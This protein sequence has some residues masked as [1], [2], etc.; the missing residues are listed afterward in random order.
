MKNIFNYFRVLAVGDI[1]GMYDKLINLIDMVHFDPDYDLL[2]FLGDYVDR[3][4]DSVRCLQYVY[5]LKEIFGDSVVCL[6]GNHEVMMSSYYLRK[7]G[8]CNELMMDYADSWFDNGGMKTF[9]Q[10]E[11]LDK[12]TCNRLI[13]WVT[14]MPVSFRYKKYFFCHAGV[15]PDVP[16]DFQTDFDLLWARGEWKERYHGVDTVVVGHSPVQNLKKRSSF[17]KKL[18]V[19]QFFENRV[20]MCDTGAF[21]SGGR[22]S[23]V[24]VLSG[25]FWQ[26]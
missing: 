2:V 1:H 22:L 26:A 10:L 23:C 9:E 24:D 16:L 15:D 21:M 7:R 25:K 12:K 18:V 13:D 4:P 6:L 14:D 8:I 5:D 17:G 19:P 3:G 20:I 11:Q